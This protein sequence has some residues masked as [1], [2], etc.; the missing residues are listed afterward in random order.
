MNHK[1]SPS[2]AAFIKGKLPPEEAAEWLRASIIVDQI[3]IWKSILPDSEAAGAFT[4]AGFTPDK[5]TEWYNIGATACEETLF[6][7]DEWNPVTVTNWLHTN[8]LKYRDI[9]QYIHSTISPDKAV[10]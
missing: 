1:I 7:E 8:R 6:V 9:N 5:A 10:E 4:K 2:E 3:L